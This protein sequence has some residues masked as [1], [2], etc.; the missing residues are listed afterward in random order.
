KTLKEF[1]LNHCT[2]SFCQEF[3]FVDVFPCLAFFLILMDQSHK[4]GFFFSLLVF[5]EFSHILEAKKS[6]FNQRPN[7]ESLYFSFLLLQLEVDRNGVGNPNR[8]TTLFPWFPFWKVVHHAQG[9]LVER[10][11]HTTGNAG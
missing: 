5:N 7:Q 10:G 1:S 4:Y 6:W 11:V 3:Q 8:F 9:F 2:R